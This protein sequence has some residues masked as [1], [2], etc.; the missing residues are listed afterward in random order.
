MQKETIE[1]MLTL[2]ADVARHNVEVPHFL[3]PRNVA[4]LQRVA[5]TL[6]K[7]YSDPLTN[8]KATERY[9]LKAHDLA[10]EIGAKLRIEKEA[11]PFFLVTSSGRGV[12]LG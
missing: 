11:C 3:I 9:E 2:T 5:A 8:N 4:K 6:R 7:H 12:R 1:S 10:S